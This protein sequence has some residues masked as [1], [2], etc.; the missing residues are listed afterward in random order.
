VNSSFKDENIVIDNNV[1]ANLDDSMPVFQGTWL[2]TS[3]PCP[4]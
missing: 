1:Y 4:G 3:L 2:A